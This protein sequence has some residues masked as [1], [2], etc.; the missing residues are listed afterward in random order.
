MLNQNLNNMNK[1]TR[2]NII[3]Y[4]NLNTSLNEPELLTKNIRT[5]EEDISS[6]KKQKSLQ[7]YNLSM[8][9]DCNQSIIKAQTVIKDQIKKLSKVNTSQI[10][11]KSHVSHLL[12]KTKIF[13]SD[14]EDSDSEYLTE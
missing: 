7:Q 12:F 2:K 1:K 3:K 8:G 5:Q 13:S 9:K 6:I 10:A 4:S 11:K 14:S